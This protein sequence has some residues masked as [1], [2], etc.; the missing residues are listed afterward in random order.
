M[1][2]ADPVVGQTPDAADM[3]PTAERYQQAEMNGYQA[4]A[5]VTWRT[6][7]AVEY[8]ADADA[9]DLWALAVKG[10][11]NLR[12]GTPVVTPVAAE[13]EVRRAIASG[14]LPARMRVA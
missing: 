11:L 3:T 4:F 14:R 2:S 6:E 7:A 9:P 1:G 12:L 8:F 13:M 10:R 5:W